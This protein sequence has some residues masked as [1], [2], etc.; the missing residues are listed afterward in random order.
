M[1]VIT[2]RSPIILSI[3]DPAS[4]LQTTTT[5]SGLS[6]SGIGRDGSNV[7]DAADLHSVAREGAEGGLRS[8]AG[9]AGLVAAGATDLDVEGG[10]AELLAPEGDVL[11]GKHG[12]VR[13]GLV[14][15]GLDL[16]AAGDADEGL[17]AGEVG[18]VD[19]GVIEGG[20]EVGN[21][22]YLLTLHNLGGDLR[23]N[24]NSVGEEKS[25]GVDRKER[26]SYMTCRKGGGVATADAQRLPYD[27]SSSDFPT[28]Q[29]V[30]TKRRIFNQH[31][32][33]LSGI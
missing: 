2:C 33:S 1:L 24:L 9:A 28:S 8:G 17:A 20:E 19:E 6:A 18:H 5:A 16:H 7:L 12:G 29:S 27:D 30:E 21:A 11:G 23:V 25:W 22:E 13:A 14:A 31:G 4:Y 32:L 3:I 15:V 10:D 26:V